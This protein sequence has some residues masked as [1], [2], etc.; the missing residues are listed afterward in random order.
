[1]C[2]S[3]LESNQHMGTCNLKQIMKSNF[4][5]DEKVDFIVLTGGSSKWHMEK[6]YLVGQEEIS[7]QHNQIWMTS[8]RMKQH[9]RKFYWKNHPCQIER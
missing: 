8:A 4:S 1:M 9:K 3:D 7:A 2:G 5:K 6:E